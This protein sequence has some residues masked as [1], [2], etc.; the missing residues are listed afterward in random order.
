MS[1][2]PNQAQGF[3]GKA[4]AVAGY[5]HVETVGKPLFVVFL[6]YFHTYIAG[7]C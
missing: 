7:F 4:L 6:R 2:T 3:A 1:R 5:R